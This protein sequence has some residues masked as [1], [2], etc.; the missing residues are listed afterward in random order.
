M[1]KQDR[2]YINSVVNNKIADIKDI[3]IRVDILQ[4][5]LE[6]DLCGCLYKDCTEH[7]SYNPDDIALWEYYL[8]F[9]Q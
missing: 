7:G 5:C 6:R 4:R 3:Q 2:I 8:K 1:S 9:K